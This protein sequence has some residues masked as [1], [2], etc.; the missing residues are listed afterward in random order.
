MSNTLHVPIVDAHLHVWR[1]DLL[2]YDWLAVRPKINRSL[3]LTDYNQTCGDVKVEEMVFVQAEVAP[4]EALREAEWVSS[5][6]DQP[7]GVS[8]S[9]HN[10]TRY[11][12]P[13]SEKMCRAC[14]IVSN[15]FS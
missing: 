10:R 11:R 8:R 9:S 5:L 14:P 6:A 12:A 1:K 15:W 2:N 3:V 13:I 4:E 7:Y